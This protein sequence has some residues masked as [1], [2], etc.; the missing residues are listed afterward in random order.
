MTELALVIPVYN[1][2]GTIRV[3]VD[4]WHA[5][6]NAAKVDFNIIVVNDGSTD[7]TMGELNEMERVVANLKVIHKENSGHGQSCVVG[8]KTAIDA[9]FTWIMQIDS[10]GQCDSKY[11]PDFWRAREEDA[12]VMGN[13]VDRDDGL[14]RT[15][16]SKILSLTI[17]CFSSI[18][19]NDAN[20]PYRL[21]HR[22]ALSNAVNRIPE[23]FYL[24]N[25]LLS[26]IYKKRY[27]IKWLPIGFRE[28]LT[29]KPKAN[30]SRMVQLALDL[31]GDLISIRKNI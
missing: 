9:G 12:A 26:L 21:M 25:V 13:R 1:E 7:G 15:L 23:S 5:A 31:V 30:H 29:G 24:S 22:V 3:V 4:E 14:D 17:F 18:Y 2:Q 20:V 19:I 10:D 8:Y 27:R 28:R 6:L 16:I 11:F